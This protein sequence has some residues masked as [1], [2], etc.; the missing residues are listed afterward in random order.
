MYGSEMSTTRQ[1]QDGSMTAGEIAQRGAEP[2]EHRLA[3]EP[4]NSVIR[5]LCL[6]GAGASILGSLVMQMQGRKGEALFV[7]QWAPTL[8]SF[9]L[10]YQI[11]KSTSQPAHR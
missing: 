7:G 10:W 4:A 1:M 3:G 2:L 8:I 5:T 6:V 9:A 11:V